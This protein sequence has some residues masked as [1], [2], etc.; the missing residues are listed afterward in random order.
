M[1]SKIASNMKAQA[2]DIFKTVTTEL[3]ESGLNKRTTK[4]VNDILDNQNKTFMKKA[5]DLVKA[6]DFVNDG[7]ADV[8][9][10]LKNINKI[11]DKNEK[12]TKPINKLT[13]A[14]F[15]DGTGRKIQNIAANKVF[16]NGVGSP[17]PHMNLSYMSA[18]ANTTVKSFGKKGKEMFS[19]YYL[20]PIARYNRAIDKNM[21][22]EA[23]KAL[24]TATVRYGVLGAG[25]GTAAAGVAVANG[26]GNDEIQRY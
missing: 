20:E 14:V 23:S 9:R 25:I 1:K 5:S 19:D 17:N 6:K 11:V 12:I 7:T 4:Y 24:K 18:Y 15:G 22:G 13:D 16:A 3:T 8:L 26:L 10:E 21:M 2:Q